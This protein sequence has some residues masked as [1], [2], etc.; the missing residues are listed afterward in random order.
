MIF[1]NPILEGTEFWPI[2]GLPT[3]GSEV[4]SGLPTNG[5]EVNSGTTRDEKKSNLAGSTQKLQNQQRFEFGT[6]NYA[7]HV[8]VNV[9]VCVCVCDP[10]SRVHGPP[11]IWYGGLP[12]PHLHI[13]IHIHKHIY[14]YVHTYVYVYIASS[15]LLELR[16][17]R[18]RFIEFVNSG[19]KFRPGID[20]FH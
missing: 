5:S 13:H 7:K 15:A 3:N 14:I 6:A 16:T 19:T 4:N 11:I 8:Y 12:L 18:I 10:V 20:K 2:T 9:Y 17:P 1:H